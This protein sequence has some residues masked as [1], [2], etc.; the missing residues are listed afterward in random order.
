MTR[1]TGQRKVH[2]KNTLPTD[3]AVKPFGD[4]LPANCSFYA[5]FRAWLRESSY[6]HSALNTYGVAVRLAL[7]WLEKPYWQID[8]E[9]DLEQVRQHLATRPLTPSTRLEYG[10]GLAKLAQYLRIRCERSNREKAVNW[11]YYLG[12]LPE[13]LT[14]AVRTYLIHCRRAWRPEQQHRSTLE[15]LSRLT[16]P[17]RWMA[18]HTEI[19]SIQ[20]I[21]PFLWFEY[22]EA[23][24]ANGIGPLTLNSDLRRLQSFLLFLDGEGR[25]VCQRM[26]LVDALDEGTHLPR[27]IPVEQ[28]RRLMREIQSAIVSFHA[29]IRRTGLM[30]CA[31]FLL[32]LHSG[33][34]TCE[35]RRLR[36]GDVDWENCRLRIEQSK[37]LKDRMVYLSQAAAEALKAYLAVRGPAEA[38]PD[39][40]F[41]YRHQPLGNRYC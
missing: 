16:L 28:L 34:R 33:L 20:A 26:L 6:S 4:W 35:V 7:G 24:L 40:V 19:D 31:W 21:T 13:W 2:L 38:L 23:R 14:D 29:G 1:S 32:M 15:L 37:G 10:K 39:H 41:I 18:A 36:L 22:I 5:N 9:S 12:S 11:D 3:P 17:L 30:D 25:P 8:P 27:D